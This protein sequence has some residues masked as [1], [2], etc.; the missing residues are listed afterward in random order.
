MCNSYAFTVTEPSLCNLQYQQTIITIIK[1]D[2]DLDTAF[3]AISERSN[4]YNYIRWR[5]IKFNTTL[6]TYAWSNI[7]EGWHLFEIFDANNCLVIL[8]FISLHLTL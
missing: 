4:L 8:I 6:S 2:G 1:C 5:F 7:D 3:I